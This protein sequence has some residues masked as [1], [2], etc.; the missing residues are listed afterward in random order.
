M[1]P[2][3]QKTVFTAVQTFL[4]IFLIILS[5]CSKDSVDDII[6]NEANEE[7]EVSITP[8]EA[9][10]ADDFIL[11]G[12]NRMVNY[13]LPKSEYDKYLEDEG[14]FS[15]ISKKVYEHFKDDFDFIFVLSNEEQVPEGLYAGISYKVQ[16]H[17]EGIGSGIYNGSSSYGSDGRLK[18][19]IHL[20]V[21]GFIVNGPFL[22]EIVHYWGNQGFIPT[23]VGG[24]WGYA[25]VGG[26]LGGFNELVVLSDN[27]YQGKM[28]GENGFGT[29]ANGGNS[30]PYGNLELYL[31]GL[32]DV[33]ELNDVQY[34]ENPESQ[35]SGK[36][37]ADNIITRTVPELISDHGSRVPSVQ[38]SQKEFN[39]I[40]V[41]LSYEKM[42]DS[43][44]ATISTNLEN[45]ARKSAPDS[46]WN[47]LFNFW[48]A[49]QEKASLS[50]QLSEVNMK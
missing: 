23:T 40:T 38:N 48:Q 46:S 25:N 35:G 6:D 11:D 45:F 26:Q 2:T 36:F 30:V 12:S 33:N 14:D 7:K 16:N 19:I 31:M 18:S 43:A 39:A 9:E 24:H 32:I 42:P 34:A 41:V 22:H 10:L 1:T 17:V 5:S 8:N 49:T 44:L 37:T 20:P 4:F 27:T 21:P 47:G 50:I 15:M 29:F 13:I 28:E 3:Y